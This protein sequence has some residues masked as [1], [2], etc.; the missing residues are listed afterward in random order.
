MS[1][2]IFR[3]KLQAKCLKEFLQDSNIQI[4]HSF[5]LEAV[6][7]M[8]AFKNWNTMVAALKLLPIMEKNNE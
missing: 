8:N 6:A 3:F 1:T 7:R 5:A 2:E 4:T